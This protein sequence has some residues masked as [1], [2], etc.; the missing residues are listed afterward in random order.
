MHVHQI[1]GER[2]ESFFSLYLFLRL[3]PCP[4]KPKYRNSWYSSK[5]KQI[6]SCNFIPIYHVCLNIACFN[7][8]NNNNNNWV[9]KVK[10]LNLYNHIHFTKILTRFDFDHYK[11]LYIKTCSGYQLYRIIKNIIYK[12]CYSKSNFSGAG[13]IYM[14]LWYEIHM[15]L[16]SLLTVFTTWWTLDNIR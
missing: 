13:V 3:C 8:K 11:I 4:T 9:S 6:S 14:P 10:L 2:W 16:P 5:W 12:P 1:S 15:H 7:K